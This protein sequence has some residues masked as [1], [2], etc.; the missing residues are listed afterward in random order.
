M[1][2]VDDWESLSRRFP[3]EVS[4]RD[5]ILS[6]IG[7]HPGCGFNAICNRFR[8]AD[9]IGLMDVL[10]RLREDGD[11]VTDGPH[12]VERHYLREVVH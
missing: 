5:D 6:Y 2:H 1:M 3:M 4:L 9:N 12:P 10:F 7:D 11:I 8:H